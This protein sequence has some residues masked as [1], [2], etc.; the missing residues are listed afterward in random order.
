[1]RSLGWALTQ[2]DWCALGRGDE[3]TNLHRG[4][5]VRRHREY[6]TSAS[7]R[8]RSEEANP[9]DTLSLDF[10]PLEL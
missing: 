10:Q 9:T 2:S 7:Q 5:T 3:D 1:M 8:D 4:Q 6:M